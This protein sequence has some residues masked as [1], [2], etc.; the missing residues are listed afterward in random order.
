MRIEIAKTG[1]SKV[2]NRRKTASE[3]GTVDFNEFVDI[4]KLRCPLLFKTNT[5]SGV[6]EEDDEVRYRRLKTKLR[7]IYLKSVSDQ[8]EKTLVLTDRLDVEYFFGKLLFREI[9]F[10]KNSSQSSI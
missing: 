8:K 7:L 6:E 10:K 3:D 1:N 9:E 4:L 5:Y 2:G